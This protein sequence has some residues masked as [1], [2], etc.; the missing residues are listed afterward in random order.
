M[1]I[2]TT[3]DGGWVARY[4]CRLGTKSVSKLVLV[5]TEMPLV[6]TVTRRKRM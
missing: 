2:N 3:K 4:S 1:N 6:E 5:C